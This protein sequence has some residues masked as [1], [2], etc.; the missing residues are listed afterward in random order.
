[1]RLRRM[2]SAIVAVLMLVAVSGCGSEN[3]EGSPEPS[4]RR[5]F[6]ISPATAHA[7]D[8]LTLTAP[9]GDVWAFGGFGMSEAQG[10]KWKPRYYLANWGQGPRWWPMD[11]TPVSFPGAPNR[12]KWVLAVPP[13][14]S[15]GTYEICGN[16]DSACAILKVIE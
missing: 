3:A 2:Y 12:R 5:D 16:S 7:G 6:D 15:P 14:A 8:R 10:D 1:M 9:K 13:K 4:G 11:D